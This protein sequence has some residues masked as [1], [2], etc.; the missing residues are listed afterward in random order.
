MKG[1][2]TNELEKPKDKATKKSEKPKDK[3]TKG[4]FGVLGKRPIV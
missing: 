2:K 1:K 3:S 4:D